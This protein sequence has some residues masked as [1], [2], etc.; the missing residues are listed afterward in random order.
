MSPSKPAQLA[1]IRHDVGATSA[2]HIAL[3]RLGIDTYKEH[4]VYMRADCHICRSEG[5]AAR[6][7]I[8][9]SANGKN[10]LATLNV[11]T[12]DLLAPE[13]ASLSEAAWL[14]LGVSEDDMIEVMHPEPLASESFI[15]A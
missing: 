9:V 1:A 13:Q 14:L 5:F 2:P 6:S 15:R 12:T 10:L 3:R 8:R 4:I 7:R 11:I